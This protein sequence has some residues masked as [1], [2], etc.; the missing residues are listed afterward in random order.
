MKWRSCSRICT[1]TSPGG[2]EVVQEK[3]R[4]IVERNGFDTAFISFYNVA[5]Q[6]I[7]LL[8][9]VAPRLRIVIHSWDVSYLRE[10]RGAALSGHLP[11]LKVHARSR[12]EEMSAYA[13]A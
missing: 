2:L 9:Q 11:R 13:M 5:G 3:L 12:G 7:P 1:P 10:T 6:F 4:H 8:R